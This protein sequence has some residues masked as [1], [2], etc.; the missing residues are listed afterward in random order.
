MMKK[1]CLALHPFPLK[2]QDPADVKPTNDFS[3]K[4]NLLKKNCQCSS[5]L[6]NSPKRYHNFSKGPV[7]IFLTF[8]V[9][10]APIYCPK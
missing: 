2:I 7:F 5:E 1:G 4:H 6:R 9:A 8:I 3:L 10:V